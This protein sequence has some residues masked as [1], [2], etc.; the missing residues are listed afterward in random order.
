[1]ISSRIQSRYGSKLFRD[2]LH[3]IRTPTNAKSSSYQFKFY[4]SE[5]PEYLC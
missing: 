1:M 3:E 2:P 5:F 4:S